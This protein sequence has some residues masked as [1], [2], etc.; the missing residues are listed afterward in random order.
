MKSECGRHRPVRIDIVPEKETE[1]NRMYAFRLQ[2]RAKIK[3]ARTP[4]YHAKRKI[5][6]RS[7]NV[8]QEHVSG[9]Y[10]H[11]FQVRSIQQDLRRDLHQ[12]VADIQYRQ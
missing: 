9:I 11:D 5:Y 1:K 2:E 10:K 3:Q 7:P 4:Y 6:R 12:N 8:I